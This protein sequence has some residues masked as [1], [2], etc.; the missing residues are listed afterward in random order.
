MISPGEAWEVEHV[1]A[2]AAGGE[3]E[4]SNWKLAHKKCHTAK[5]KEDHKV[6]SK[7]KRIY[8]KHIGAKPEAKKKIQSRG[9]TK[10]D[11]REKIAVPK[12]TEMFGIRIGDDDG[13]L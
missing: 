13:K 3:D 2:L 1:I 4:E 9:F 5:T 6:I 8:A 11:K 12:R 10:K 7:V